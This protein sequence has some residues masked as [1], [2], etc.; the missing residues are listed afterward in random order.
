MVHI[1]CK[2]KRITSQGHKIIN[3]KDYRVYT[4]EYGADIPDCDAVFTISFTKSLK[5]ICNGKG[6]NKGSYWSC[7]F[8]VNISHSFTY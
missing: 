2:D 3:N 1:V 5:G 8:S 6:K 7:P 4:L